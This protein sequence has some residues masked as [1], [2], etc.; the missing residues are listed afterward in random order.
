MQRL[1]LSLALALALLAGA[2]WHGHQRATGIWRDRVAAVTRERDLAAAHIEGLA[3][4]LEIERRRRA[5]LA[6][7][8]ER[9]ADADDD[10]DRVSLPARSVRRLNLR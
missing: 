7:D 6:D 2:W 10:A 8:L 4:A 1:A 5:Q 3:E 9:L